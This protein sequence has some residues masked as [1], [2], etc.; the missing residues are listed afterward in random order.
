MYCSPLG[1][2]FHGFF[3][4]DYWSGWDY[5][6]RLQGNLPDLGIEPR[7]P[8]LQA[9]YLSSE[10]PGKPLCIAT[11]TEKSYVHDFWKPVTIQTN[12]YA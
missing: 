9:D 4:Q 10:P 2:S 1:S 12:R 8:T 7:S 6:S 3:R 5:H 11:N